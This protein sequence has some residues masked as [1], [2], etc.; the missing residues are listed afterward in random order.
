M[1]L[2]R[3][4]GAS[5][6]LRADVSVRWPT[7]L[8][9]VISTATGQQLSQTAKESSTGADVSTAVLPFH[10]AVEVGTAPGHT[11]RFQ[12]R[13]GAHHNVSMCTYTHT[14]SYTYTRMDTHVSKGM[15]NSAR[16]HAHAYSFTL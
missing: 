5:S 14:H 15:Q 4:L 13:V 9:P 2:R 10:A 3:P 11:G 6:E 7:Q 12:Y 8:P 16:V 1:Q